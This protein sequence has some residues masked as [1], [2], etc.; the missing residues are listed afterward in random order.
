[1]I[2]RIKKDYTDKLRLLLVAAI[3]LVIAI[4]CY[5]QT[6]PKQIFAEGNKLYQDGQYDQAIEKYESIITGGWQNADVYYNLGNSYFKIKKIGKS[7]LNYERALRLSPN[8]DNFRFNLDYAN[9]FIT[10]SP[11]ERSFLFVVYNWWIHL[12]SLNQLVILTCIIFWLFIGC[13]IALLFNKENSAIR[14]WVLISGIIFII[15]AVWSSVVFYNLEIIQKAIVVKAPA[16]AR[17]GPGP[18]FSAGFTVP[19]GKKVIIIKEQGSWY[20]IGIKE[21]GL[22]GWIEKEVIEKI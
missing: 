5:V 20:E 16:E 22:K 2:T 6:D 14:R 12:I 15:F 3:F 13:I 1:M 4:P 8:N 10:V 9:S 19:E 21:E 7:I 11:V 17:S 18:D